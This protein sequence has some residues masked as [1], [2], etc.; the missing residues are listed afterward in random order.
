[1]TQ[2]RR[3]LYAAGEPLGDCA[4]RRKVGRGMLC[5]GGGSSSSASAN[6]TNNIDRRQ[7]VGNGGAGV[8]GD[9]SN[10]TINTLDG[11]VIDRAFD[12]VDLNNATMG[13]GLGKLLDTATKMFNTSEGL[14][15]QTQAAVADAYGQAQTNKAGAI[16]QKTMIVLAVAAAAIVIARK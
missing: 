13:E 3:T 4:T 15:G 12:T 1:M 11:G 6:T 9:H 5:G 2:S 10:L 16:D 8:S 7:A 14:I